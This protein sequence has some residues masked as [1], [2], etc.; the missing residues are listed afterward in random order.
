PVMGLTCAA[1]ARPRARAPCHGGP[2]RENH[3]ADDLAGRD[4]LPRVRA[5]AP[6]ARRSSG[7]AGCSAL[8]V[9]FPRWVARPV[10]GV[11]AA[12][13]GGSTSAGG[14]GRADIAMAPSAARPA[15]TE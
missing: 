11:Q 14:F 2:A 15:K 13:G 3:R 4:R 12:I 9:S 8:C 7:G 10:V 6:V 5:R 1:D